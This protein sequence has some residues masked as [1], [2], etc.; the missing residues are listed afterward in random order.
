MS[1][2]VPLRLIGA[3]D[4]LRLGNASLRVLWPHPSEDSRLSSAN[5]DSLVLKIEFGKRSVLLLGDIESR[6]EQAL[7][8]QY[9]NS[10]T[11][12][13]TKVA[14]HGSRTSSI[15][16]FVRATGSRLAVISVGE[17]SVFGHPHVEV[18][19]RWQANGA[20]V[21]TTGNRGMITL[22]TDGQSM[23]LSTFVNP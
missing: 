11:A 20:Q 19:E 12:D 4:E 2:S 15:K 14:H 5:N 13:V 16:S 22:V 18:V 1:A 21:I 10:L 3:G 7:A 8:A 9:Q 17:S 6:A 23:Q